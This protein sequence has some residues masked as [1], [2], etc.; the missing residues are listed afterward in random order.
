MKEAY[1]KVIVALDHKNLDDAKRLVEAIEDK[2]NWFK[3]GPILFL[4]SGPEILKYLRNKNKRV[5]LDLKLHDIPNVVATTTR[6]IAEM[7][8]DY[9]T[10]HC[11]GG[12][13]MLTEASLAC[14][15]MPM[16]LL[17]VTFL[18]SH[19]AKDFSHLGLK[20][21][22]QTLV[23]N[24]LQLAVETRLAGIVCSPHEIKRVREQV[25]PGFILVTPGIR[26]AD[27]E[28][29]QDDQ[30][31]VATPTEAIEWG[32]NHIVV[33]RPITGSPEP[34]KVVENLFKAAH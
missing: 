26:L 2:I 10:I 21:D 13:Q 9:L 34:R 23:L 5:F 3:V 20:D 14:R 17:G 7:G 6:M 11:L 29:Y 15:G 12:R 22:S 25:L 16:K 19:E 24:L 31:R 4:Q 1:D 33:G 30:K 8:V 32:A 18:T 28:V 27:Q